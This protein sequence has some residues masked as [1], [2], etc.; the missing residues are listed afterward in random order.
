MSSDHEAAHGCGRRRVLGMHTETP[1]ISSAP[2]DRIGETR[3]PAVGGRRHSDGANVQT[4]SADDT[5]GFVGSSRYLQR[6][7]DEIRTVAAG[8]F[9]VLIQGDSGT[10]KELVAVAIHRCSGRRERSMVVVNCAAVPH[11]LEEAAFFGHVKGAFTGADRAHEGLIAGA[12]DSTLFLDE[13]AE[14]SLEVQAKLLRVLDT[15]EYLPVGS[16]TMRQVDIRVVSATNRN[17]ERL[18]A[19]G[20]FREDLFFRLKGMVLS[21]LPLRR[22]REDIAELVMHFL[23]EQEGDRVPSEI[24]PSALALLRRYDWPGNVRELRYTVEV[25]CVASSGNRCIDEHTVERVLD[26][27]VDEGLEGPAPYAEAKANA[28]GAFERRYFTELLRRCHGNVTRVAESAGMHRP[29][30]ARKLKTLGI[31]ASDYREE[32]G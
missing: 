20:Q 16:S 24:T 29:N 9:P 7:R 17:L 5:L 14:T 27:N 10:G 21:T 23:G 31:R 15:G 26:L 13:I 3:A 2:D 1:W 6:L 4:T 12:A 19:H 32:N 25:L 8:D 22:H 28:I 18:V 30:V 11:H